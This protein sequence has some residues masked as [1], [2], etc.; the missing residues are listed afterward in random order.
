MGNGRGRSPYVA[1]VVGIVML[2]ALAIIGG[3]LR[4]PGGAIGA[5]GT[6]VSIIGWAVIYVAAT[7]GLGA[8]IM[9]RFGTKGP[10]VEGVVPAGAGM[11]AGGQAR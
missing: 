6:I 5:L 11:G 4:L 1:V 9:S 2:Q 8:V 3:I 10:K 7:V